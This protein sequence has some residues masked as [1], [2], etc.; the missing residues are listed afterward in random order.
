L[1]KDIFTGLDHKNNEPKVS[2]FYT[3]SYIFDKRIKLLFG[4]IKKNVAVVMGGYSSEF[5]IS[6]KSG[7]VVC[8]ALDTSI[9]NVFPVQISKAGWF[10]VAE[11]GEKETIDKRDFSF[12]AAGQKVVPDVLFNTVHGTPGE[13]GI[14]QAY[15]ELLG[16]PHTSPNSYQ[17]ALSFNKRDCLSVLK[18]FGIKCAN[19]YYINKET[20]YNIDEIIKKVGLPCFVKPNRAGS[21]YGISKVNAFEDFEKALQLAFTEDN[22]VLIET[23]LVGTEVSV[24]VYKLKGKIHVFMPTEIVSENE[25][26]DFEAK[27]LGKSQEITPA[28]IPEQET[29]RVQEEA[30]KIYSVLSMSGVTRSEFIIQNGKPYLIE[31]NTTP[32]LS[33]ESIVPKQVRQAGLTLTDFFGS[34][35]EEAYDASGHK[36]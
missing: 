18:G 34:L 14:L 12:M 1:K 25:F 29:K 36:K 35:I 27:Y 23:A 28:R 8:D 13:D 30:K 16:I 15:W 26:F 22:E 9:Y 33:K 5:E 17:S 3:I 32:G 2:N 11:N 10:Y 19:S 24:G 6:L 31:T 20:D 4:M 7:G 21:S